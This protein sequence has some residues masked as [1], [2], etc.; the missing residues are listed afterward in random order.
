MK[1]TGVDY[2]RG[3]CHVF[4]ELFG[5]HSLSLENHP[6][7]NSYLVSLARDESRNCPAG[8]REPVGANVTGPTEG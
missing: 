3:H 5:I 8:S 6:Q 2:A 4:G 7:M 1:L